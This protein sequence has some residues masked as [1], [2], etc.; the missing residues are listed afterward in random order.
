[1]D[2]TQI[3]YPAAAASRADVAFAPSAH[4]AAAPQ[5]ARRTAQLFLCTPPAFRVQRFGWHF[6]VESAAA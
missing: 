3:D 6:R 4:C 2:A 1:M 5:Q